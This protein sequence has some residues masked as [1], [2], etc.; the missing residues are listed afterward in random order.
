MTMYSRFV[1]SAILPA[2]ARLS[3]YQEVLPYLRGLE[4][5]QWWSPERLR[6]LQNQKL[7][8][9]I[10]Q[11][12]NNVPFYRQVMQARGLTP[13][14]IQT[15][16]DLIK[17]PVVDKY[18]LTNNYPDPIRNHSLSERSLI[19]VT[20]SG[21]TGERLHYWTTKAQKAKK[22]AGLFR[23]WEMAGYQFGAPY[24]TFTVSANRGLR[25]YPLLAQLEWR[26][27][28]HLWLPMIE[29]S[30][31]KLAVYAQRLADFRP[32]MLRS[33]A[34]TAYFLARSILQAG[35]TIPIPAIIT[36]GET[37]TPAMREAIEQ[38]FAPGRVFNE[39]GGDGMQMAGE[40]DHHQ[41]MHLNAETLFVE[42]LRDGQ[43]VPDG[44]MGE[45]VF[46]NLEATAMPFIRYNIQDVG[47]LTHEPCPCGRGLP[48]LT[49]LEG[50]LTDLFATHDGRWLSVHHFTG[51]F[52]KMKSVDAFQAI[53]RQVDDVLIKLVANASFSD[54]DRQAILDTFHNYLGP[55]T[56]LTLEF[57]DAIPTTPSGKRRFFI[58]Q[59]VTGTGNTLGVTG[60]ARMQGRQ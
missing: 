9:L 45:L 24:A 14:D 35:L 4:A 31:D 7:R 20:S 46:T 51:F 38:A 30:D 3:G 52:G 17:L 55:A 50:R 32:S 48:R 47:V 23:F 16:A 49:H 37:L 58:S 12:Y 59:V 21:S 53:Q 13:D 44:E 26:L 54:A 57:V 15:T 60:M 43:R 6:D 1:R 28:R 11:A 34:S 33:Y 39:Y 56:R 8:R 29:I 10:A 19:P 5:S 42:V 25:Q 22:W 27:L 41:G 18:V 40:C 36:T 2:G